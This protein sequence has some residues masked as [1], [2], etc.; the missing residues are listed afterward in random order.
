[1]EVYKCV[2]GAGKT[3]KCIE[4]M[5]E[6]KNGLYLAYNNSVVNEMKE[7]GLL[8]MTI[9]S[10]FVS[11]IIPKIQNLIPI[12]ANKK[13]IKL[14]IEVN[15][16][17][18]YISNIRLKEDGYFYHKNNRTFFNLQ[19]K[20]KELKSYKTQKNYYAMSKIITEDEI[21]LTHMLRED[22]S[23]YILKKYDKEI[24]KMLYQRFDYII[25]DEAQDLKSYK[26]KFA[27][28]IQKYGGEFI[29]LGDVN[30]NING[31]GKWFEQLEGTAYK[32]K[33]KR[34]PNEI[35]EWINTNLKIEIEGE[36]TNYKIEKIKLNEA[37]NLDDGKRT[38]LYYSASGNEIKNIINNWKGPISTIKKIKGSTIKGD[39]VVVAKSLN[40]KDVYTAFTRTT[41]NCYYTCNIKCD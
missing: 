13:N 22:I 40:K 26:E 19:M 15:E 6:R 39:I 4:I 34:V 30:Q 32:I 21:N 17:Y 23:N 36:K 9:D 14:I 20:Q 1:M 10:L 2:A 33:S 7:H 3:T 11:F 37:L 27:E 41:Q 38:M 25:I 8:A 18:R 24:V 12:F 29:V 28:S 31:G 35:C 5:K 16:Q